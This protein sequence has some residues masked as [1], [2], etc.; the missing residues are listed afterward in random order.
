MVIVV[1]RS[2]AAT[3]NIPMVC[4]K[5]TQSILR[6]DYHAVLGESNPLD[7]GPTQIESMCADFPQL[8]F[9]VSQ[10]I[11]PTFELFVGTPRIEETI[12]LILF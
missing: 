9:F 10:Q 2:Y 8:L 1:C 12:L 6:D 5:L 4:K 7:T 11:L 3:A